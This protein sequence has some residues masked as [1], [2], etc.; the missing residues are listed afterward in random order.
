MFAIAFLL[1]DIVALQLENLP[2]I[3]WAWSI[4]PILIGFIVL[5]KLRVLLFFM[6]GFLWVLIQGHWTLQSELLPIH[7]KKDLLVVG[8]IVSLPG[9][10][11]QR[12]RF[13]FEIKNAKFQGKPISYPKKVLLTWYGKVP[14]LIADQT[15]QLLVRLKR[16]HGMLNPGVFDYERWLFENKIRATGYVRKSEKNALIG[17]ANVNSINGLR[18]SIRD[19]VI[20]FLP[21]SELRGLL[22]ALAIGDRSEISDEQW[23]VLNGTGTNH[24][25]AIS[26]L[27][28]GLVAGIV[29]FLFKKIFRIK[30]LLLIIPAHK[31]AAIF[32]LTAAIFYA[33]L[34]GF[35]I[36][37][38]RALIMT[39]LVLGAIFFNKKFGSFQ[40]LSFSLLAVLMLDPFS[41]LAPGFWLSFAAVG[42]ILY[43]MQG[44][45]LNT[46]LW[47]KFGRLQW[48]VSIALIPI[49]LLL[50]NQFSIISPLA[51]L[52][53]VPWVSFFVVPPVLL[54]ILFMF[55]GDVS[56]VLILLAN[57]LI[58]VLWIVLS[59]FN[60]LSFA[61]W[62]QFSPLSWTLIPAAIAILLLLSPRGFP[63][64]YLSVIFLLPIF[65]V[66]PLWPEKK[67]L[68]F[69]LLDVGQGLSTIIQTEKHV[70]VY[71]TGAKYR[72]GFDLGQSVIVPYLKSLGVSDID[73]LI[74]SHSDNDH[75]G[76][77]GS[78]TE[79]FKI[80]KLLSGEIQKIKYDY[81]APCNTSN[82][83]QWDGVHFSVLHPQEHLVAKRKNNRSCVIQIK[84][85]EVTILLTGD[86]ERLVEKKLL[87]EYGNVL[88]A[89]ILVVPHH[90]SKTSSSLEF[91][92]VVNPTYA[93]FP[94]GY[95]NRFNFPKPAIINRYHDRGVETLS[96]ADWG[97]I[98]FKIRP[99][100]ALVA[101]LYRE[102]NKRFWHTRVNN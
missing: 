100:E 48:I 54:S 71:D 32:A 63:A 29:F 57:E 80:K 30:R 99:R 85:D 72:S 15:W 8:K 96:T 86:I 21:D 66:L 94:A 83:W 24:L 14:I 34:A 90:G 62:N 82:S 51:N 5:P 22:L 28:I 68:N 1:G 97:A 6:L 42:A 25:V 70:L 91:I 33:M 50:F 3:A 38:Q 79:S 18:Q 69:T 92:Q 45:V 9:K 67:E 84:T 76:G 13:H 78:I 2:D 74:V 4:F 102:Q 65:V 47:W 101:N 95:A 31:A 53:A 41:A 43:A 98:S 46:G 77:L 23:K 58:Q 20:G 87:Q 56:E 81:A 12:T 16:P 37:T 55:I 35:S 64:R 93:L 40:I 26:G 88:S 44:R 10:N 36:P 7:E 52:F 73:M 39:M 17:S 59:Y 11:Q 89:D 27:H 49:L 75:I 60:N 61:Q 19:N